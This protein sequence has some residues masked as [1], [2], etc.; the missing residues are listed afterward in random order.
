[1]ISKVFERNVRIYTVKAIVI[2]GWLLVIM[3]P[4]P[5]LSNLLISEEGMFAYLVVDNEKTQVVDNHRVLLV[6][7]L[8]GKDQWEAPRHPILPYWFMMK[9][10]RPFSGKVY[11]DNLTLEAK[12]RRAR[13]PFYC[14]YVM[15][16]VIL[17]IIGIRLFKRRSLRELLFPMGIIIFVGTWRLLV[18]GSVQTYYDG[19]LGV[20]LIAV[21]ALGLCIAPR[22]KCLPLRLLL[23][24]MSGFVSALGKNEWALGL[25]AAVVGAILVRC[26][27]PILSR[28]KNMQLSRSFWLLSLPVLFGVLL[29]SVFHYSID[30]FNYVHGFLVMRNFGIDSAESWAHAFIVRLAWIWPMFLLVFFALLLVRHSIKEMLTDHFPQMI[31]LLWG[32]SMLCGF[33]IPPHM[34]DG[35]PRLFCPSMFALLVFLVA[36]LVFWECSSRRQFFFIGILLCLL[37]VFNLYHL[38]DCHARQV[39]IGTVPG[40]SLLKHRALY[41]KQYRDFLRTRKAARVDA[42]L[43]Y[44]FPDMDFL[45]NT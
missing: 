24:F 7:R 10:L 35:F 36:R 42:A 8:N 6:G 23:L 11:F 26:A 33:M 21:C 4:L 18:G 5:F 31:L 9:I 1:M 45:N 22:I 25:L 41:K 19:N 2:C 27:Y 44:Y 40:R 28:T 13:I 34:G 32:I 43:G 14:L 38:Y 16:W 20:F 39:S 3:I 37:A 12:T 15:A 29:G 17:F 30:P